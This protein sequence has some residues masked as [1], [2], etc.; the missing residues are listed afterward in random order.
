MR[1]VNACP[2]CK[3]LLGKTQF[4][5]GFNLSPDYFIFRCKIFIFYF[6]LCV[7]Q[8]PFFEIIKIHFVDLLS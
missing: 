5:P 7:L 2:L 8:Q 4:S 3:I 6:K 1:L